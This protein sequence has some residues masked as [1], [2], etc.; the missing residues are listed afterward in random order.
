MQVRSRDLD[1]VSDWSPAQ[2]VT[3]WQLPGAIQVGDATPGGYR[4][5][6]YAVGNAAGAIGIPAADQVEEAYRISGQ[7]TWTKRTVAL[8]SEAN[9][10]TDLTVGATYELR[11]RAVN[12]AGAGRWSEIATVTLPAHVAAPA[13][14]ESVTVTPFDRVVSGAQVSWTMPEP[15]PGAQPTSFSVRYAIAGPDQDVT[16]RTFS[17][18]P[19][20]LVALQQ[21]ETYHVQ[22][23]AADS[24]SAS[25]W[26]QM[27]SLLAPTL[28]PHS[29]PTVD[30]ITSGDRSLT[31]HWSPPAIAG[32]PP[33]AGIELHYTY[34]SNGAEQRVGPI[35][36]TTSPFRVSRLDNGV[37]YSLQLSAHEA[38]GVIF[39]TTMAQP[40]ERPQC[41][42]TFPS[43][44]P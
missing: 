25:D 37:T 3:V 4:E 21:G 29:A 14:P 1:R 10:I 17:S 7:Q 39:D 20:T 27:A 24:H 28:H 31:I 22:V 43:I 38:H 11:V 30:R 12:Q 44:P 23:S 2:E 35:T 41:C 18:S 33:Y 26:S 5:L 8:R 15:A 16:V 9:L 13:V 34:E 40:R 19:A 36:V 42:R 6:R 32:W